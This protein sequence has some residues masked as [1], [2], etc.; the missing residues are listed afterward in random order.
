[1]DMSTTPPSAVRQGTGY[2]DVPMGRA[3]QPGQAMKTSDLA[4]TIADP[5][6]AMEN[7]LKWIK[8]TKKF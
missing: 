2:Q 5:A 3:N 8:K 1:M 6:A 4:S 7:A